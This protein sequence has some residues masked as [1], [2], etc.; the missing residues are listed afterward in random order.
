MTRRRTGQSSG[1]SPLN[2][3]WLRKFWKIKGPKNG[4][5]IVL[6]HNAAAGASGIFSLDFVVGLH[7]NNAATSWNDATPALTGFHDHGPFPPFA[8]T[9]E[10]PP[11]QSQVGPV[12][13]GEL[14]W[15]A[16]L[17]TVGTGCV[18]HTFAF[19]GHLCPQKRCASSRPRPGESCEGSGRLLKFVVCRDAAVCAVS[20]GG[21]FSVWDGARKA[22]ARDGVCNTSCWRPVLFG[23]T[24]SSFF[25]VQVR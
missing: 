23:L 16:S 21:C 25:R 19:S 2:G 7:Q 5:G 17:R 1:A 6:F 18:R 24:P 15:T 20:A 8:R 3:R 12:I 10:C 4:R 22:D 11:R 9:I 13:C 14:S